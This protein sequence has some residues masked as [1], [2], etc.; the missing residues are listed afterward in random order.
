MRTLTGITLLAI[1][2]SNQKER[3][4]IDRN[5]PTDN[6]NFALNQPSLFQCFE[7][8]VFSDCFKCARCQFN[9]H[10]AI[11]LRN[12]DSAGLQVWGEKS[13]SVGGDML[14]HAAFFLGQAA[15]VNNVTLYRFG[16]CDTAFSSHD[17][18]SF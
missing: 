18:F 3:S 7:S 10:E 1:I 9:S 14:T 16:A 15:P 12:P 6:A 5:A 13:W 11:Q 4:G 8:A 17:E 2:H